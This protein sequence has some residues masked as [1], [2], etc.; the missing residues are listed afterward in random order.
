VQPIVSQSSLETEAPA[1]HE[2]VAS[3]DVEVCCEVACVEAGFSAYERDHDPRRG[4]GRL[5]SS[6]S[7][8]TSSA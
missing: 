5:V 1:E 3:F 2:Y 7:Y 8:D 4:V 6:A